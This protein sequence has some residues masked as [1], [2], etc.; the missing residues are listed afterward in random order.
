M[1][2]PGGRGGGGVGKTIGGGVGGRRRR[3]LRCAAGDIHG[4]HDD[5][6]AEDYV[7]DDGE[8]KLQPRWG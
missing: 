6:E 7:A 8:L 1:C 4:I 2:R 3:S 5:D